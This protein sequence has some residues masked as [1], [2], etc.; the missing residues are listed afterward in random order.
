MDFPAGLTKFVVR[1]R[2]LAGGHIE[3]RQDQ[4]FSG[5]IASLDVPAGKGEWLTLECDVHD[6][7]EG[8]QAL[9]FTFSGDRGGWQRPVE[10]FELDWLRFE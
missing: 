10:L 8:P 6:V 2:A 3:V 5:A 9:W 7:D 4:S 1:V